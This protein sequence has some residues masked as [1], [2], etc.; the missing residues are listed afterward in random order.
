[1][2]RSM[3]ITAMYGVVLP[4]S[5]IWSIITLLISFYVEKMNLMRRCT[6]KF[7]IN[8]KLSFK[9]MHMVE[10]M[11]PIYGISY[12][13]FSF[14]LYGNNKLQIGSII[15]TAVSIIYPYFPLKRIN[16][17]F[18]APYKSHKEDITYENAKVY[19]NEN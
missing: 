19:W 5:I 16:D 14:Y 10:F 3:W 4:I 2:T 11:I 1:M 18:L 17:F 13:F 12:L 9:I 7:D 15:A 8:E 6:I